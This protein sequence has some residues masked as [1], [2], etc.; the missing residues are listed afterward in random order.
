MVYQ[1]FGMWDPHLVMEIL[2]SS[3]VPFGFNCSNLTGS[4]GS[5]RWCRRRRAAAFLFVS[6]AFSISTAFSAIC[7]PHPYTPI[8]LLYT[9]RCHAQV[10]CYLDRGILGD[11]PP[12]PV[13][14]VDS[15]AS[16]AVRCRGVEP[17]KLTFSANQ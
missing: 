14:A 8:Y 11:G 2:R 7:L 9:A 17:L 12:L 4:Y 6:A 1:I 15:S 3:V 5:A 10:S 16:L 13:A